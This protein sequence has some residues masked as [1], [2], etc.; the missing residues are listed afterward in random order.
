MGLPPQVSKRKVTLI[1][2]NSQMVYDMLFFGN[3]KVLCLHEISV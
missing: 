3:V 1:F 2:G